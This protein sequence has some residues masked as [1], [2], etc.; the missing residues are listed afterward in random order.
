MNQHHSY[1]R[2]PTPDSKSTIWCNSSAPNGWEY[3]DPIPNERVYLLDAY[4]REEY[5]DGSGNT[6]RASNPI[7]N[8][9][10]FTAADDATDLSAPFTCFSSRA[11]TGN[12]WWRADFAKKSDQQYDWNILEVTVFNTR[13]TA[14]PAQL[15]GARI[16]INDDTLCGTI[17]D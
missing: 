17:P 9:D 7:K 10:D 3:C 11:S 2:N 6:F 4:A 1:C 5:T 8:Y 15:Q 12:N 14:S 16:F 13:D